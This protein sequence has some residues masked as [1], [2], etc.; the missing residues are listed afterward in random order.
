[1]SKT[2][3]LISGQTLLAMVPND[4]SAWP[5]PWPA[6]QQNQTGSRSTG[7]RSTASQPFCLYE[8]VG[9]F[10][11]AS[12]VV[13]GRL[14]CRTFTAFKWPL[15]SVASQ[16][17]APKIVCQYSADFMPIF[18]RYSTTNDVIA[19]SATVLPRFCR[20]SA[21]FCQSLPS[22]CGTLAKPK[23]AKGFR[24]TTAE[25]PRGAQEDAVGHRR[26]MRS[27]WNR[28]P[29]WWSAG[30]SEF[31][32]VAGVTWAKWTLEAAKPRCRKHTPTQEGVAVH[33]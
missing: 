17:S 32:P 6:E 11:A 5:R 2:T 12:K 22:A 29:C 13:Q 8:A 4:S 16:F 28:V 3:P 7:S 27:T 33:G 1:M 10:K 18:C 23:A 19:S 21:S 9:H 30:F 31:S 25:R 24:K 20:C 26:E 15:S 14:G